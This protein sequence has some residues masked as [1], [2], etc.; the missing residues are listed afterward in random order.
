MHLAVHGIKSE[1]LNEDM[2]PFIDIGSLD[3]REMPMLA[4]RRSASRQMSRM[5]YGMLRYRSPA[6]ALFRHVKWIFRG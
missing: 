3:M 2:R 6:E 5:H 4:R 1:L